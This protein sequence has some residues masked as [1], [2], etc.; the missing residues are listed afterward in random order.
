[1]IRRSQASLGSCVLFCL[2]CLWLLLVWPDGAESQGQPSE[3]EHVRYE[4]SEVFERGWASTCEPESCH[5]AIL[6][7]RTITLPS[8]SQSYDVVMTATLDLSISRQDVAKVQ[9]S[10]SRILFPV[11]DH[12]TGKSTHTLMWTRTLPGGSD[13]RFLVAVHARSSGS[14]GDGH[15]EVRGKRLSVVIDVLPSEHM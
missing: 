2:V 5:S 15:A 11:R 1:M 13:R 10:P 3:E 9:F 8:T 12:V 4:F 6:L 14:A 7:E